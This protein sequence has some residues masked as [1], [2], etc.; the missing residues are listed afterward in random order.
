MND[1]ALRVLGISSGWPMLH[2]SLHCRYLAC[3]RWVPFLLA[4]AIMFLIDSSDYVQDWFYDFF[5]SFSHM[6]TVGVGA[7]LYGACFQYN[8]NTL[9]S[10]EIFCYML[11]NKLHKGSLPPSPHYVLLHYLMSTG[12][13]CAGEIDYDWWCHLVIGGS[14]KTIEHLYKVLVFIVIYSNYQ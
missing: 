9:I 6:F 5:T 1:K 3:Y 14:F 10:E 11:I 13:K 2:G 12:T 4:R 7:I 8:K